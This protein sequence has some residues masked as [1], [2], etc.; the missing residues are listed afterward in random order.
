MSQ[1]F[2]RRNVLIG[3]AGIAAATIGGVSWMAGFEFKS[4][5][6]AFFKRSLPGVT[7]DEDSAMT[8]IDDFAADWPMAKT[9]VLRT[10]WSTAGVGTMADLVERFE[11]PARHMLT[12]FLIN[13]NF[14]FVD[15]PRAQPIVYVTPPP[16][17]PCGNP[18]ANLEL[19]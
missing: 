5:V 2:T 10:A 16:H 13:S 19:P 11:S 3:T 9:L 1:A 8:S 7:I 18:F 17:A 14:F 15:D 4:S 12:F 6:L